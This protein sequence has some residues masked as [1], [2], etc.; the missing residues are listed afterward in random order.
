MRS[1]LQ[2]ASAQSRA[3]AWLRG[4][5]FLI[6]FVTVC[7]TVRVRSAQDI[8]TPF[9]AKIQSNIFMCMCMCMCIMPKICL[10]CMKSS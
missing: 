7:G 2:T 8:S 6:C 1:D 10:K 9:P 4:S 5:A 3:P